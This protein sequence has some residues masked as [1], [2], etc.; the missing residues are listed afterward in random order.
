M[1]NKR[2]E[3]VIM[4]KEEFL[5]ALRNEGLLIYG[6]PWLENFKHLQELKKY[7]EMWE[8]LE[9]EYHDSVGGLMYLIEQKYFPLIDKTAEV[10]TLINLTKELTDFH[11]KLLRK[12]FPK[13]DE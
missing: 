10:E 1:S 2:K 3:E 9:E 7:K 6:T 4:N 5:L 13:E 8:K 11:E 12:Y